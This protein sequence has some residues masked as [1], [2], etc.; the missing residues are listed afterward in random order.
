MSTGNQTPTLG[1]IHHGD[2]AATAT[3]VSTRRN[4]FCLEPGNERHIATLVSGS[5]SKVEQFDQDCDLI[6]RALAALEKAEAAS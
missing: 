5:A 4:L 3:V 2:F 1:D 6:V